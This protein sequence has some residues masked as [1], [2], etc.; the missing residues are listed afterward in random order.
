MLAQ[1]RRFEART[2]GGMEGFRRTRVSQARIQLRLRVLTTLFA[3]TF[4]G[5][6]LAS[7]EIAVLKGGHILKVSAYTVGEEEARLTLTNG[8]VL[9]IPVLNLVRILDD[10]IVPEVAVE[11]TPEPEV[12]LLFVRGQKAPE[13]PY[14]E[15]IFAA[16]QRRGLNP[17]LVAAMV[18]V[19]SAFRADATS[20]KGARGLMQLMPATAER[21]GVSVDELADPERNLEAGTRYLRWL[22][23]RFGEDPPRVLAAYNAGEGSVDRYG[24]IP[25]YR[26]TQNYVRK[27]FELLQ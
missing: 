19:E 11:P 10:E 25:P 3:L 27:I 14:G 5:A 2:I 15:L 26:E 20:P 21:F 23:E 22:L 8:G 13:T 1:R 24:G 17:D 9:T 16:A 18:R 4:L 6:T 12:Q 7:A